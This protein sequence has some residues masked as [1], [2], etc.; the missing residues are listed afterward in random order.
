MSGTLADEPWCCDNRYSLADVAAGC[1]LGYLDL[2]FSE[3]DW[4][5]RHP[6]LARLA[7]KLATRASFLDTA[8]GAPT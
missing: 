2:R 5:D 7:D 3:I 6:N 4:R 1:A 8:P